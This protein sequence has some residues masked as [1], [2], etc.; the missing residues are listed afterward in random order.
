M[1]G[2]GWAPARS[3][4]IVIS[5]HQREDNR[6]QLPAKNSCR[7]RRVPLMNCSSW[8]R[9][10]GHRAGVAGLIL[11]VAAALTT[12]CSSVQVRYPDGS[13]ETR[14]R[15]DFK[16]YVEQVFRYHNRVVNDLILATSLLDTEELDSA[17]PLVRAEEAMAHACQPLNDVVAASIE[18]REI[19]FFH[20]L[21]LPEAVP[22]CEAASRKLEALLP[23]I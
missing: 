11:A 9:P 1:S 7:R 12:S 21:Q 5:K 19:G 2:F 8:P 22:A 4:P 14:S 16:A 10:G 15:A 20:K 23:S 6:H 18:G 17:S 13:I 3:S